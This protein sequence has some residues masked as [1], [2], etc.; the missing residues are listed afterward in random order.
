[1]KFTVTF[2]KKNKNNIGQAKGHNTRLHATRSQL[3]PTAWFTTK[4]HHVIASWREDVLD[5][6]RK[7][8]KRKDAVLAIELIVQIGNQTDWREIPTKEAP[9]GLPKAGATK[10]LKAMALGV[11][12]AIEKEFGAQNI[13]SIEVHTDESSP[14]IHALVTPVFEGKLQAKRW[15]DGSARCAELRAR[16]HEVINQRFECTYEKGSHSGGLPHDHSKAAGQSNGPQPARGLL[17]RLTG[18]IDAFNEAKKLKDKLETAY[19]N[20]Q[21]LFSRLK[22]MQLQLLQEQKKRRDAELLQ[23]AAERS[24]RNMH[25]AI[26]TLRRQLSELSAR[27]ALDSKN[28]TNLPRPSRPSL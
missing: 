9:Y 28:P 15:L 6:A 3:L 5:S 11:R 10:K 27:E 16:L 14:H 21:R 18:G 4:G 13:I 2:E 23:A 22:K 12:S 20:L 26:T 7:L 1:M 8:A 25:K 17:G 19:S 24:E